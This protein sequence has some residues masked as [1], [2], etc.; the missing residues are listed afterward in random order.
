MLNL[1]PRTSGILSGQ[2]VLTVP[3]MHAKLQAHIA[4][5]GV[6]FLPQKNW[7]RFATTG[8][9]VI[10]REAKPKPEVISYLAWRS[11]GGKAQKWLP[12]KIAPLT[13]EDLLG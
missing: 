9:L 10:K 5:L 1:A 7:P 2:D 6:G 3:D 11:K 13:L 12:E 4:G 8:E